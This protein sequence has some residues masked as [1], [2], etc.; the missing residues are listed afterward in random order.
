[1]LPPEHLT[2]LKR[3]PSAQEGSVPSWGCLS[4]GPACKVCI[5]SPFGT[6]S[7]SLLGK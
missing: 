2:A 5:Y 4:K 7:F 1:M 6:C 3:F